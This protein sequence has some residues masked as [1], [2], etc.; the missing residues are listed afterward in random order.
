MDIEKARAQ[1]FGLRIMDTAVPVPVGEDYMVNSKAPKRDT[2]MEINV[3]RNTSDVIES[4]SI[5]PYN[6]LTSEIQIQPSM[7]TNFQDSSMDNT[8]GEPNFE[9]PER[10]QE[11]GHKKL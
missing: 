4:I 6:P 3:D 10:R 8:F 2:F 5:A 11:Q 1:N 9:Y 7:D